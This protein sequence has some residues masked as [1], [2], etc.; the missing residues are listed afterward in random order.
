MLDAVALVPT[1]PI[2]MSP[3]FLG[4]VETST[5]LGEARTDG[6]RLALHSLSRSSNDS[7]LPEVI[8]TLEGIARLSGGRLEVQPN[9]GAWRP[10][11]DSS[12]LAVATD[13]YDELFGERPGVTVMHGGL[14]PAVIGGK[15][16]RLD[17]LSFGP[18]IELPH[19]PEERLSI[20]SVERFWA[21]LSAL[22][23]RLSAD[24]RA[25]AVR[26]PGQSRA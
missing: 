11:L 25:A 14:E 7:A 20:S 9:Y 10:N 3:D 17:M 2:A 1:G 13:L 23:D 4:L 21:L 18:Q 15:L 19:S 16:P 12:A 8:A 5:S 22:V 24:D 26:E 6:D